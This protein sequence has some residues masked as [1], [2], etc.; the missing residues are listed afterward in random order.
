MSYGKLQLSLL[1]FYLL[2]TEGQSSLTGPQS[3]PKYSKQENTVITWF[4]PTYIYP[5]KL[6]ILST[7]LLL[8]LESAAL[9]PLLYTAVSTDICW[10]SV[11]FFIFSG[12]LTD[13]L[14]RMR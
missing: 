4:S 5:H 11:P 13:V 1:L 7:S 6:W 10:P 8:G 12:E 9:M 3:K 14:H 2:T